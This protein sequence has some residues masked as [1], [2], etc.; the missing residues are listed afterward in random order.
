MSKPWFEQWFNT[1]Y[2]HILYKNRDFDEAE[3]FIDNLYSFMGLS[4]EYV[5]DLACGKGRHSVY[6]NKK[7]LR[8]LGLDLAAQSIAEAK[9]HEN[10]AL[11][12]DTHDMRDVY[13]DEKF[14][15]V[16]NLFTSFGY[17]DDQSD[18]L[19]VLKSVHQML[20]PGGRVLI[21]FLN[22]K[23]T[24]ANLVE[25][26]VKEVEGIEFH[27][28]RNFNGS[29]ILKN[30]QFTA[31]GKDFDYTE[32]VQAVSYDDFNRLLTGAGFKIET[33]FGDFKLN[34]FD[35]EH[36]ERLIIVA[37]KQDGAN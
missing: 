32:K 19:Q 9:K 15:V 3:L 4:N 20:Q 27:I 26:E 29:H 13:K 14:D 7:G 11:H 24:L 16:F 22:A 30:I 18:N 6:L 36:S 5:C 1:K 34:T 31:E 12:F 37:K 25:D 28:Q 21:D 23:Y 35:E 33:T 17:F 10:D 2:Y 8:V